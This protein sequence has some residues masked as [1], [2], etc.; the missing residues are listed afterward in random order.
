M[1]TLK[2]SAAILEILSSASEKPLENAATSFQ[3]AFVR[4]KHFRVASAMCIML[5]DDMLPSKHRLIMLFIIHDLY[6]GEPPSQHP[7]LPFFASMVQERSADQHAIERQLLCLLLAQAPPK[8]LP[9]K[10]PDEFIESCEPGSEIV[11][12]PSLVR[13]HSPEL[14][15]KS[16]C[17]RADRSTRTRAGDARIAISST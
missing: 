2:E 6:K 12:P 11:P 14:I 9:K 13:A 7:F 8:D 10:T 17:T 16:V 3:R 15:H 1:L 4:E 5:Q